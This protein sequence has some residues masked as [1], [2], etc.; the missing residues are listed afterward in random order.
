VFE[1]KMKDYKD[2]KVPLM[3]HLK[4]MYQNKFSLKRL[5]YRLLKAAEKH[6]DSGE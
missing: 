3:Y 1:N 4:I 6:I 2:N 5:Y